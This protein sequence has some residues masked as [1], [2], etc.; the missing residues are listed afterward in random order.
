MIISG[1]LSLRPFLDSR[2]DAAPDFLWRVKPSSMIREVTAFMDTY[3]KWI[4][5]IDTRQGDVAFLINETWI[6]YHHGKLLSDS[7]LANADKYQ[8]L[9]YA[10]PSGRLAVLPPF[11]EISKR[12]PDF[13][14]AMFGR[15]EKEI[16]KHCESIRFLGHHVFVN[17]ICIDALR[18]V[19]TAILQEAKTDTSVTRYLNDLDIF[20]SFM[21]KAVVGSKNLS[22]HSFGLAVDLVPSSY[23]GRH[24]YWK[25]S[26]VFNREGWHRIPIENRW[27]P[28]QAVIDA[29]EANGFIWGGKWCHFDT[30]H[31]E[32]RPEILKCNRIFEIPVFQVLP[33]GSG[34]SSLFETF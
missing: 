13:L 10:Y 19:E 9:F 12:S 29:F 34:G 28:P 4:T 7:S 33:A 6:H 16:R 5:D 20:Y 1:V 14:E 2:M 31:F 24:V 22:Y 30:I 21:I 23:S 11:K 27:N 18:R 15:T 32:Y 17:R 8:S 26:R 25:W 3:G